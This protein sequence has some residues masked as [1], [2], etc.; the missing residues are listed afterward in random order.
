MLGSNARDERGGRNEPQE[1][2]FVVAA[3]ACV[4]DR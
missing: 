4:I 1:E 3:Q 2:M